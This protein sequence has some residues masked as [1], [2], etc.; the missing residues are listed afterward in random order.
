MIWAD[1]R[2]LSVKSSEP[3]QNRYRLQSVSV[4]SAE[5]PRVGGDPGRP[6]GVQLL[7]A[8]A[9]RKHRHQGK[10]KDDHLLAAGGERQPMR[11]QHRRRS[12]D[13]G[14]WVV[15]LLMEQNPG[16]G[17]QILK[18]E[19]GMEMIPRRKP[20][21][22]VWT[23]PSSEPEGKLAQS[24]HSH[25]QP[26]QGSKRTGPEWFCRPEELVLLGVLNWIRFIKWKN[27]ANTGSVLD[28]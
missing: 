15:F 17:S 6:D 16:S 1:S 25:H 14:R 28:R 22:G 11:T 10:G 24:Q 23:G 7:P 26:P 3:G 9:P 13:G 20:E 5:D 18:C 4:C 2:S 12:Q 27:W 19:E 21:P 8:G